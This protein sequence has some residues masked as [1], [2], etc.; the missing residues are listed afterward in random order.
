[1][2][3]SVV[4]ID[5]SRQILEFLQFALTDDGWEV[6]GYTYTESD[7][8]LKIAQ[9]KPD[10]IILD[11]NPTQRGGWSVLQLLRMDNA[12]AV[13]PILVY[14]TFHVMPAHMI[15]YLAFHNIEVVYKPF[16]PNKFIE[17]ITAVIASRVGRNTNAP[18]D[19]STPILV[20]EDD[21]ALR[22]GIALI[23][24]MEGYSVV[25]AV[26]GQEAFDLVTHAQY[27]LILLDIHMPVMDGLQF[28]AAYDAASSSHTPV[29]VL[30]AQASS[31]KATLP[32]F[33]VHALDK[34]YS[35]ADLLKLVRTQAHV[36]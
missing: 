17:T 31:L 33:V 16:D 28:L 7:L 25:T 11:L 6:F 36:V 27:C 8:V 9:A 29:I 2:A 18:G 35:V 5:D 13:I 30:S 12:T 23:L 22:E 3:K 21:D 10:V 26:N 15:S 32:S 20:V 1:M 14:T 19:L 4:V 34:P 24:R